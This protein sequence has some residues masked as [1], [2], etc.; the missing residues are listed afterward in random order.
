MF[1]SRVGEALKREA[2]MRGRASRLCST[3]EP[4]ESYIKGSELQSAAQH[5]SGVRLERE[6]EHDDDRTPAGNGSY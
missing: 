3:V 5:A 1:V 4:R 6:A 2:V